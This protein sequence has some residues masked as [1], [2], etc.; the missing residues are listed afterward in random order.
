MLPKLG[1]ISQSFTH[2]SNCFQP[3]TYYKKKEVTPRF[4]APGVGLNPGFDIVF[5]QRLNKHDY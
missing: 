3:A 2:N 4:E 5:S 1:L